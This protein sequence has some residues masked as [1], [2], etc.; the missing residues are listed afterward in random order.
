MTIESPKS[1][2]KQNENK[3]DDIANSLYSK[4]LLHPGTSPAPIRKTIDA[5]DPS[6]DSPS[7]ISSSS[8]NSD[9]F[10]TNSG[11]SDIISSSLSLTP[12]SYNH[13]TSNIN[14][15]FDFPTIYQQQ[16]QQQQQKQR[17]STNS[18]FQPC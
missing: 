5:V 2:E 9:I 8:T 13:I 7:I 6:I 11:Y 12:N 3:T 10:I 14:N 15:K 17:I 4:L 1:D 16:Q 18:P